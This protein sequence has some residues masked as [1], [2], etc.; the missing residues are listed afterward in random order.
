MRK[1][2]SEGRGQTGK[3]GNESGDGDGSGEDSGEGLGGRKPTIVVLGAS[4]AEARAI[5]SD[6]QY[7]YA[8]GLVKRLVDFGNK[9]ATTDLRIGPFKKFWSLKLKGGMLKKINLRIYFAFVQEKNEIVVLMTY[10]KEEMRR[11]SPHVAITLEDR[12]EDYLAGI[13]HGVS[14]RVTRFRT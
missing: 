1:N 5:L 11:V 7:W 4:K 9:A 13:L 12:L 2:I 6:S 14:T 10:K 8:V 3:D